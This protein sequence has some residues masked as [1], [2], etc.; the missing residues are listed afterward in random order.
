MTK[1]PPNTAQALRTLE[2][3]RLGVVPDDDLAGYTVGRSAEM[4]LVDVDLEDTPTS[5]A[6]RAFLGEYGT[7][8]THLLELIRQRA[9]ARNFIT[10]RVVLN[11]DETAPSHPRRV[12]REL[13][14]SLEYPDQPSRTGRGLLPLLEKASTSE[15][16]LETFKITERIRARE[17]LDEGAHLYLTPAI[18]YYRALALGESNGRRLKT[19][20][21]TEKERD[22]GLNVMLQWLSGHPTISNQDIDDELRRLVG[23]QGR[24]YSLKDY[25]P[26][27]RIYGY[28]LSG[29]ATL[30]RQSG[31]A[32]LA[33]LIDEAEF[34]SLLSSQ[35]RE[36]ARILFK[37]LAWASIGD[38][39]G[40]IPFNRDELDLGG[41]GIL[42]DL[43]PR[44]GDGGGLYT[45]F[46]MTPNAEGKEAL[47]EAVP[48]ERTAELSRLDMADYR[49]L[50]AAVADHYRQARHDANA[51]PKVEAALAKVVS[52]LLESAY[53]ENP[54]Q[55]MKFVVEFLDLA[56]FRRES[57]K[58][59][60]G[61]LRQMYG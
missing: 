21:V 38:D 29:L 32:G 59:V 7:G 46:A 33:V 30:A 18:R 8:K 24:I 51:G 55:A 41:M 58:D 23:R 36:Y 20:D 5:G 60:V 6:L 44:Y 52:G 50:V 57:M 56:T 28:I 42:Q 11:P 26:W 49:E 43:P 39:G 22:D 27:A 19:N 3:M 2:A 53:V 4:A 25:R 54:R 15:Q 13:L 17:A 31:Y 61:D 40:E 48:V 34:Y 9:V 47:A 45:V 35:N 1:S 10:A 12:Y 16:V 37:A 14:R